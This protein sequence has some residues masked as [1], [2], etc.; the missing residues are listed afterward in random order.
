MNETPTTGGVER[1]IGKGVL[2]A[3]EFF[4]GYLGIDRFMRGQVG[5]GIL[6]ILTLG[7]FV[8]GTWIDFFIIV[9]KWGKYENEFIF[10]DGKWKI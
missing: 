3:A 10:I 9:S 6:K 5:L 2:L 4:G 1:R 7:W 8:F